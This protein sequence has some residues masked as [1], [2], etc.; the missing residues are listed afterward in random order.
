MSTEFE[1]F[2]PAADDDGKG[3]RGKLEAALKKLAD[4]SGELDS[5]RTSTAQERMDTTWKS[6]GVPK[7]IYEEFYHGDKD[8][9]K[10]TEWWE[11]NKTRFNIEAAA[12]TEQPNEQHQQLAAVQQA[13]NL[14][15][16]VDSSGFLDTFK[17]KAAE[18]KNSSAQR[19][20]NALNE[21]FA[22]LPK[23]GYTPPQV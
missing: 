9:T 18:M 20:P 4:V 8:P 15:Q 6:L 10:A 14:G 23:G 3:L 17:A 7:D 12:A 22:M 16:D 5:L 1:E 19:N 2:A 13:A 11:R 21:L